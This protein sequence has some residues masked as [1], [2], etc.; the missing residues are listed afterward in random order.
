MPSYIE[1]DKNSSL[2]ASSDASK[3]VFGIDISGSITLIDNNS[4][5]SLSVQSS[6]Y[7]L[8]SSYT[9]LVDS[10]ITTMQSFKDGDGNSKTMTITNGIITGIS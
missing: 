8:T 1:L 6:S 10:G 7:A 4:S 9:T 5:S 3:V 2:P